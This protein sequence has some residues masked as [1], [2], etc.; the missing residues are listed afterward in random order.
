MWAS[1]IDQPESSTQAVAEAAAARVGS[2][3][4]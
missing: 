2:H 4:E 1:D 3:P